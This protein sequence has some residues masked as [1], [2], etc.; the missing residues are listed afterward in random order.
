MITYRSMSWTLF[1]YIMVEILFSFSVCFFIFFFVFLV[2]QLLLVAQDM[3]SKKV[4]FMQ[5]VRLLIYAIP[6]VIALSAPFACM[7]GT[8]MTIGRLT[9]DNEILVMLAAGLSYRTIFTPAFVMGIFISIVSFVANDVLLPAGRVQY[10]RLYRRIL[11]STPALELSAHSVKRFKDTVIVTG[12]VSGT[13]ID[14][15]FILDKTGGGERRVIMAKNAELRDA[16]KEGL[17]LDLNKAFIQSSK[18]VARYDYDYASS[19]FLRYWVPQEDMIQ[20]LSSITPSEMSSRDV[21]REI[22]VKRT[23]LQKR[24]DE[25]YNRIL[26]H[27]LA[28]E[29]SLRKGPQHEAWNRRANSLANFTREVQT[30]AVIQR[31]R[32]LLSY[33]IEF[34]RKFSIPFGALAFMFLAVPIG[35]MVKKSGQAIGFIFGLV[36]AFI[37]W[38]MLIGGQTMGLRLGYPPFWCMWLPNILIITIGICLSI[39][40][41]RK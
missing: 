36:I 25:R 12:D 24:L 37:Y 19:E 9:S 13:S 21:H 7:S 8:L 18:E 2:N 6:S 22:G 4:P 20:A 15:V 30:A 11:A 14:D 27:A 39:L 10:V 17:S 41:I 28:L 29:D 23:N 40:R 38:A 34:Y 32:S 3:L 31:D 1:K 5:V 35:L 26:S 33:M 16:G